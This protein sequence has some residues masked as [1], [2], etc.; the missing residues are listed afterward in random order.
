MSLCIITTHT[1][2][3]VNSSRKG[4]KLH[5][6]QITVA[7]AT[8]I[9]SRMLPNSAIVLD[10]VAPLSLSRMA[11]LQSISDQ[12]QFELP[13][14]PQHWQAGQTE[15]GVHLPLLYD[16]TVEGWP[17]SMTVGDVM[18]QYKDGQYVLITVDQLTLDRV[19]RSDS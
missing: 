1:D 15:S 6:E 3:H 11:V 19:L 13:S 8:R 18:L 7:D 10:I 17:R 14:P 12:L 9:V 16:G 2:Y 5:V 4:G